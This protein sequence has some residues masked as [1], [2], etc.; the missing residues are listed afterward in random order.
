MT[1]MH[2]NGLK[3]KYNSGVNTVLGIP[4]GSYP[5]GD[6]L[7]RIFQGESLYIIS[8]IVRNCIG[9]Y[10][11][12]DCV[13]TQDA[14]EEAERYILMTL[15]YD[16]FFP[17]QRLAQGTFIRYMEEYRALDGATMA[18]ILAQEKQ[19]AATDDQLFNDVG[20][21]TVGEFLRLC[22]NCY[23]IDLMNAISLFNATSAVW[24]GTATEEERVLYTELCA[25]LHDASVVPG[26]V[27]ETSYDA[28]AGVFDYIFVISSFLAMA[29]F[30]F[31]HLSESATKV[32]RCQN[33]EC[34][35]FFT[36]KR[37]SAKYCGFL[38]P[39]SP[40]RTCND[41]YPQFVHREK[42]RSS[43]LDRL[44][45]NAKGRLY[46]VRRRH[47]DVA[48]EID[49]QLSDL[50]IYAPNMKEQVLKGTITMT[51]FSDWLNSHGRKENK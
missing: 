40:G 39:Q 12:R 19:R 18:K 27:M 36:A 28:E 29:V 13:L 22:Y 44:I 30:E 26:T 21:G 9:M 25:A 47:P 49:K 7:C 1:T 38:A 8:M 31:S 24:S 43:E 14:V 42:V 33:P 48:V 3:L 11:L 37:T 32:M 45:K 51:E 23:I 41:Y 50:T 2:V 35:K 46:N 10:P 15:L 20:F 17:A 16:D 4:N 6:L 34:R 5:V